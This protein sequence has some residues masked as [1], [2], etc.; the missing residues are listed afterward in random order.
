MKKKL[1]AVMLFVLGALAM[2]VFRQVGQTAP[3]LTALDYE[4]IRQLY[5]RYAVAADS[6]SGDGEMFARVF[7]EDGVFNDQRGY[8]ELK[9][10]SKRL[11]KSRD[12]NG[13]ANTPT[14]YVTNILIE[15]TPEGAMGMAYHVGWGRQ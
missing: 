10:F 13:I 8:E 4:E 9:A 11:T 1:M 5:A 14:H 6:G 3:A 7:T 12:E 15:P 2:V